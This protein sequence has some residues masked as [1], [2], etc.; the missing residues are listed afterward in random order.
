MRTSP[1]TVFARIST[2]GASASGSASP[3][4]SDRSNSEPVEP[5]TVF[6]ST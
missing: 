2:S 4:A 3:G 1:L 5:L 6:A